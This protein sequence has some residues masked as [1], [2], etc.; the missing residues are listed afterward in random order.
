MRKIIEIENLSF[1]YDA[2]LVLENINLQITKNEFL[3]I[4]GPNG[5]GKSTLLKIILGLEKPKSGKITAKNLKIGYV[6]QNTNINLN[7]PITALDVVLMG[8]D[9][10]N[11]IFFS[12]PKEN[13]NKAYAILKTV[14]M[15][16]FAQNKISS[17]SGGQRQRIMIARA[18]FGNPSA[19]VL[20]EPTSNIDSEGQK[21]IF[22]LLKKLNENITI[23]VVSHDISIALDYADT[24]AY[25]NKKISSHKSN[26]IDSSSFVEKFRKN[27]QHFCEIEMMQMLKKGLL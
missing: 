9:R 26:P 14:N 19:L 2:N 21:Q 27:G 1:G 22:E 4:I 10:K 7:F 11:K 16:Q 25:I 20:D 24:I 8:Y 5:G 13:L 23:I 15:E 12:H 6:P 18:L 17:L 3:A